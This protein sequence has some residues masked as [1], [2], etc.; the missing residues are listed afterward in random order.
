MRGRAR[1]LRIPT[2]LGALVLCSLAA[3]CGSDSA[4]GSPTVA[5]AYVATGASVA[6]PG[7]TVAVVDTSTSTALH[8]ITTGTLP[9]ALAVTPDGKDLL[10][11]NKGV[12]TLSEVDV[13]S[14]DVVD[15]VTVGLEP[16]A[17]AV[18]PN[19]SLALVA[20]FGDNTVTPVSL[21]SF[22]PGHPI[23]VGHQP[24]A[25]AVSPSGTTALVAN[26]QDGSVTP[27]ALPRSP[28]GPRSRPG[29]IRF[30]F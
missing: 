27:I 6:N 3:A 30:L 21:P 1:D 4:V 7:N 9:A 16:D 13:A 23:A 26:Y 8:P 25:I 10:V 2:V 20:N 5:T 28:K 15:Q 18:T 17:V 22:R 19:G 24:V 14:G 11:A 12:D 29:S